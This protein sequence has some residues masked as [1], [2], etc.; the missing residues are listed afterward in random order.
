LTGF[1]PKPF[2]FS[3]TFFYK[4]KA[5]FQAISKLALWA[6]TDEI[7]DLPIHQDLLIKNVLM[8]FKGFRQQPVES[9]F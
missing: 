6:Q 9:V 4:S 5:Q 8:T 7:A 2:L 1:C 3:K